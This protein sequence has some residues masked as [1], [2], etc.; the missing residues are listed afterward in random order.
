MVWNAW[1]NIDE[2]T[3]D[4]AEIVRR[5]DSRAEEGAEIREALDGLAC[6]LLGG[7]PTPEQQELLRRLVFQRKAK[8]SLIARHLAV[9]AYGVTDRHLRQQ[10]RA[11]P[12]RSLPERPDGS[13]PDPPEVLYYL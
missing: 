9:W 10:A 2:L 12:E 11:L 4:V 6:R 8:A 5:A 3:R 13:R 1:V 7:K